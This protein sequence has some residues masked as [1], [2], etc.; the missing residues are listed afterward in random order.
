MSRPF[1]VA[2][3][4]KMRQ[5]AKALLPGGSSAFCTIINQTKGESMSV[6]IVTEGSE[7]DRSRLDE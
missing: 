5:A 7:T 4:D 2:P 1:I 6:K 3:A